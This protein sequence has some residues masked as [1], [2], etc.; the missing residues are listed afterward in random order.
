MGVIGG[1]SYGTALA[2]LIAEKYPVKIYLRKKESLDNI[3]IKKQHRGQLIHPNIVATDDLSEIASS[4]A[5]IMPVLPSYAF[6]SVMKQMAPFL[7]PAHIIIHG[8]KGFDV[9]FDIEHEPFR[10]IAPSE[11]YTMSQVVLQETPVTR[12]GCISGPNLSKEIADRQPAATVVASRFQE[13]VTL[14]QELLK[15]DRFLVYGSNDIRGIE[16]AGILKNYIAIAAGACAGMGYG[17]NVKAL[18]ITRGMAEMIYIGNAMGVS[19]KSFLGLAGIG[20]LIATCSSPLSRNYSVGFQLAKGKKL[21]EIVSQMTEAAEGIKTVQVM[22]SVTGYLKTPAPLVSIL[23]KVF[24]K[25][26][27]FEQGIKVLMNI[28]VNLDAEYI[29]Q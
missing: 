7:T 10:K 20:D 1:G 27:S 22:K 14:G 13:V 5:V 2:N 19:S 11:V 12:V 24:Y 21:T 3:N 28:P 23:Y 16:L 4:C 8:T 15:S 6:R 29:N 26:Y 25:E 9:S 17:E 18:L